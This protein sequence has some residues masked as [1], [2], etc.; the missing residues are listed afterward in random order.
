VDHKKAKGFGVVQ[1][2]RLKAGSERNWHK[3]VAVK[4][5]EPV[6]NLTRCSDGAK[7]R[8]VDNLRCL[9]RVEW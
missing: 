6:Q 4:L 1:D 2:D 8:L 5:G 3:A 7:T 9:A